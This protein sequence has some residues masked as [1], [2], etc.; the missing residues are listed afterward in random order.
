ML[1][2]E[3]VKEY[4]DIKLANMKD[5]FVNEH[6][7]RTYVPIA[8]KNAMLSKA[9]DGSIVV[10]KNGISYIDMIANKISFV[11]GV[12]RLYTDLE[13]DKITNTNGTEI[14]DSLSIY[15]LL[16]ESNLVNVICSF[17]GEREL[18][19]LTTANENILDAWNQKNMTTQAF[20]LKAIDRVT[21]TITELTATLPS[22]LENPEIKGL[23]EGVDFNNLKEIAKDINLD[24][25]NEKISSSKIEN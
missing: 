7:R 23:L 24:S 4:N 10:D 1:V 12:V 13:P 22:L 21:A 3:F 16:T 14:V 19:E 20:I 17:I 11:Y 2:S 6:I 18:L 5:E 9:L 8:E 25:L 15:D